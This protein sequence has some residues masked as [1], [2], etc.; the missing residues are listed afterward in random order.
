MFI[1]LAI[2]GLFV[3]I[4]VVSLGGG[5]GSIYVG[6]LT[7]LFHM[8]PAMAASTSLATMIPS[9]IMGAYSHYK[10]GNVNVKIGNR[11]LVYAVIGTIAGSLLSPHIPEKAYMLITAIILLFLGLQMLYQFFFGKSNTNEENNKKWAIVIFGLLSGLMVGVVGLSG[12]GSVVS[13][14]LI[15]GVP[16]VAAVGT[17]IYILVGTS[18]I[19]LIMHLSVG[20]INWTY[21]VI[22]LCGSLIGSYLGPKILSKFD[23]KFLDKGL[24]LI[25]AIL[26]IL[27]GS[28]LLI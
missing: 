13:G 22:L 1:L 21:V 16:M 19:G 6:M 10:Q 15:G 17:S 3:G 25:T 28:R 26:L 8:N 27:M 20:T 14:L 9:M 24:K 4:F 2:A 11:M 18:I 5:G 7:T 12:G 23:E